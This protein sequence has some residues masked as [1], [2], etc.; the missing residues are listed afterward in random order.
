MPKLDAG[1]KEQLIIHQFLAGPPNTVSK[2]LRA[3]GD[4]T[5]LQTTFDRAKL[6]MSLEEEQSVANVNAPTDQPRVREDR[7]MEQLIEQ[8]ATLSKQVEALSTH[9][10]NQQPDSRP[11]R[12]FNC[13]KPG[14]IRR[15]CRY[16]RPQPD[17]RNQQENS[18]GMAAPGNS[19]PKKYCAR[20]DP[21]S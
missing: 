3:A 1:A 15:N 19:H 6:L 2:Q 11:I 7:V 12:C 18:R 13:G 4:T 9:P 14:H 8:V 10:R 5:R 17:A 21:L 20:T 16:L